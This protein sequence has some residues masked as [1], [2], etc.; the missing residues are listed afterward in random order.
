MK[1]SKL[2]VIKT[3]NYYEVFSYADGFRYGYASKKSYGNN[4][5]NTT[6]QDSAKKA[7]YRAKNNISRLILGN[8][9][10][11]PQY[12][13]VFLTLTFRENITTLEQANPL[14]TKFIKR[15]DYYCK[16]SIKYIAVHEF[17]K[18][19]DFHGNIKPDGGSIHYHILIFNI[20]FIDAEVL[21]K[22][23]W[24]HGGITIKAVNRSKGLYNY[25][26]KYITKAFEDERCE[27]KK[28]YF[29][30]LDNHPD[31]VREQD[32]ATV[33][34][35]HLDDKDLIDKPYSYIVKDKNGQPV[36]EVTKFRYLVG[37]GGQTPP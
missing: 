15:L 6:L 10:M 24:K 4:E 8:M 37:V 36:D 31:Q 20:P 30:S 11:Y 27:N 22:D 13:L 32:K 9:D 26:T 29:Y 18:D 34:F 14:F 5:T 17:Q 2:K 7:G 21:G 12:R 23:I 19:I 35:S 3:G 16:K 1:K 28:R 25:I 33:I